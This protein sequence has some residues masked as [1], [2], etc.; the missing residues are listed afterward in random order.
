MRPCAG[1]AVA[2]GSSETG[3]VL[4][5]GLIRPQA[6]REA[7]APMFFNAYP[8]TMGV[9][10]GDP[11]PDGVVLWTRLAPR[12]LDGGGMPMV[13]MTC[14][15]RSAGMRRWTIAQKGRRWRGPSWGT[16]CTWRW[17]ARAWPRILVSLSRRQRDQ[18]DRPDEDAPAAGAAVDQLRFGVCGCSHYET[19]YFTGYRR[20]AQEQFDFVIHTGDYI[21]ESRA[22]GGRNE[23]RVRQHQ[24]RDLYA[25]RLPQPLRAYKSDPDLIAAHRSAPFVVSWDDH[26]VENN[27]AGDFDENGTAPIF[28]LRRAAAYQALRTH[29]AQDAVISVGPAHADLP[30]PAV[31]R[32]ARPQRARHA[33]V[34]VRPGVQRRHEDLPGLARCRAT[35]LGPEQESG[36]SAIWR[37]RRGAG[38]SC[39]SRSIRSR[40]TS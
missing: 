27:Y 3:L 36:S 29:A 31:R 8:F 35:I 23:N 10:S 22:D 14:N 2:T 25:R 24:G 13:P 28:L 37:T 4:G 32:P 30:S 33:A 39:R 5:A 17:R 26:E 19:G 34:A 12:P 1:A 15:G 20:I 16:A 7:Q 18:P 40:V 6:A 9:A 21:Y 11:L 38:P